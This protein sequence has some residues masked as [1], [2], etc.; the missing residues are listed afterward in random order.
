MPPVLF[1]LSHQWLLIVPENE[2]EHE[3]NEFAI[4]EVIQSTLW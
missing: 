3:G 4:D 1:K 2:T